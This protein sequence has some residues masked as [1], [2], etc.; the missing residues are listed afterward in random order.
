MHDFPSRPFFFGSLPPF[1]L[2]VRV[3]DG[4]FP[5]SPSF[6][7][8]PFSPRFQVRFD[9]FSRLS[10]SLLCPE[11]ALLS[12]TK[13]YVFLKLAGRREQVLVAE[14]GGDSNRR[15]LAAGGGGGH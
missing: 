15:R 5:F 6:S 13:E 10:F 9:Y 1:S 2:V 7:F 12:T 11:G 3:L 4:D 14:G 8:S